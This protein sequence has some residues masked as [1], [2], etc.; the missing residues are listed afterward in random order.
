MDIGG[1][2]GGGVSIGASLVVA[3]PKLDV[4][5]K[6]AAPQIPVKVE[7]PQERAQQPEVARYEAVRAASEAMRNSYAVSD[8][9][10]SIYK[11]AA[12]EYVTRFRSLRDGT[13]K[14]FPEPALV[15]KAPSTQA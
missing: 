9:V 2:I 6:A 15:N 13:V 8:T 10:F 12:G 7:V 1:K 5:V 14:Y 11:D 3:R 4:P